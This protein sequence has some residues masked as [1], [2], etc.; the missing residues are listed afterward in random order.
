MWNSL[1]SISGIRRRTG[2]RATIAR[3]MRALV[4]NKGG[5]QEGSSKAKDL[6]KQALNSLFKQVSESV[7]DLSIGHVRL[8]CKGHTRCH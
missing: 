2:F 8:H 6:T 5:D 4:A 3:S 7:L 1:S